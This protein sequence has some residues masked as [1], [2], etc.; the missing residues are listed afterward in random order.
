[1]ALNITYALIA[2]KYS[3]KNW[4]HFQKRERKSLT[5][6]QKSRGYSCC[7]L[8]QKFHFLFEAKY[9]GMTNYVPVVDIYLFNEINFSFDYLVGF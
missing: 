2:V 7:L 6:L 1:M 8:K 4:G 3:N 5:V 9:I